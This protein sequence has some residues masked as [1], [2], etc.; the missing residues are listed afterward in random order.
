MYETVETADLIELYK[1]AW[2]YE[3]Q[4]EIKKELKKR[5]GL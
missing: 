2:S 3:V 5:L 1:I 4:Q